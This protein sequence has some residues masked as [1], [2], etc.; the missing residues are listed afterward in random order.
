MIRN[1]DLRRRAPSTIFSS[2][3]KSGRKDRSGNSSMPKSVALRPLD[4]GANRAE[5]QADPN[6]W[7]DADSV[8]SRSRFIN[9]ET[10]FDVTSELGMPKHG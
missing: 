4:N 7:A 3:Y 5:V 2:K 10:T 1:D 9:M 6:G 8:S